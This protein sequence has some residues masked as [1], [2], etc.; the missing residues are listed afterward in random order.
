[1]AHNFI[2]IQV[3]ATNHLFLSTCLCIQSL[4]DTFDDPGKHALVQTLG[5]SSDG[6][7]DLLHVASLLHVLRPHTDPGLDEGLDQVHGVDAQ[8]V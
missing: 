6:V 3:A 1:M 5:E 2:S 4:V 8:D 7:D